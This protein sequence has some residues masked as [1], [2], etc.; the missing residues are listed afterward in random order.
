MPLNTQK[1]KSILAGRPHDR[2]DEPAAP[3]RRRHRLLC[4]F[5]A[6]GQPQGEPVGDDEF[7]SM[8]LKIWV[9]KSPADNDLKNALLGKES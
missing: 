3:A 9:G 2:G 8:V 4:Q 7:F 5:T 6:P 1:A